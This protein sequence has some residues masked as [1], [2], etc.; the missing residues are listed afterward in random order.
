[1]VDSSKRNPGFVLQTLL[2]AL[3]IGLAW[4]VFSLGMA[5]AESRNSPDHALQWRAKH[6]SA[7]FLL[8]EQQ[9]KSPAT[10]NEA[11]KNAL[12]ALHAYPLEGRAYRVLGQLAE[13]KKKPEQA[14]ELFRRA[15]RYSPR[16]IESHLWL[17]NHAL[18][19]ENAD[20]AVFHLD[21]MLRIRIDLLPQLAPT[22]AG[23]AAHP[24]SQTILIRYLAK[25]P[26]WRE[27]A[28]GWIATRK[29]AGQIYA[30]FFNRLTKSGGGLSE[31]EQKAWLNALNQSQQWSLAYLNWAM[32]LSAT[33]QLELGNLFNG[34]FE[35]EPLG[36]EFDWQFEH[37][38]GAVTDR[39]FREGA[40]G[41]LALRVSFDDR[42]VPFNHVKQT[43]VLPAGHYRLSG[44]GLAEDLR[45]EIGLVW[46]VKCLGNG[47]SL[48]LSEPMKGRSQGWQAFSVDFVVPSNEC[49]AQRLSLM[50]PTRVA[51]EQEIGGS[52]WF[53]GL[54]IQRI[55][56]FTEQ[57]ANKPSL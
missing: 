13:A 48:A 32:Q 54:R 21:R 6:S 52:V 11:E 31:V 47:D 57:K 8:A 30:V 5:D 35:Y 42:R 14:Y 43:L 9:V 17:M 20:A 45:S 16:D 53:D 26:T 4:R 34:S 41:E 29:D 28:I 1:M 56:G 55:Q 27:Q 12:A 3:L 25:R 46:S 19:T 15:V 33:R 36:G 40:A 39:V 24:S 10:Y 23:L 18:Q 37:I 38:P 51:S 50:L 22:I 7:L 2:I 49:P 44:K